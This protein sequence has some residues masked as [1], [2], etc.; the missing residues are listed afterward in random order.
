MKL[1]CEPI[2]SKELATNLEHK[3]EELNPQCSLL[4][5]FMLETGTTLAMALE[6][7]VSQMNDFQ[8]ILIKPLLSKGKQY[9]ASLSHH[10]SDKLKLNCQGKQPDDYVFLTSRTV[11]TTSLNSALYA[12]CPEKVSHITPSSIG[13]T[14]FLRFYEH[15]HNIRDIMKYTG[16][17]C[18]SR[19]YTYIGITPDT[20]ETPA[21]K[22]ALHSD[23]QAET[24]TISS[25]VSSLEEIITKLT[26]LRSDKQAEID[27]IS[28]II[29]SMEEIVTK[30]DIQTYS[31]Q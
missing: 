27:A 2:Y 22:T 3:L 4:F 30:L 16:H 11:F 10:L 12:V 18:P 24:N 9:Y 1:A 17:P 13:K 6:F 25:T 29:S 31:D 23:R 21:P 28:S 19:A 15:T 14:Y 5:R 20:S 7:K 8:H 26:A